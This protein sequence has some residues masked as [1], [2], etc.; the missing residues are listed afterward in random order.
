MAGLI[1]LF[2]TFAAIVGADLPQDRAIDG[3]NI[4]PV[5]KGEGD[6]E[7]EEF[8]YFNGEDLQGYRNALWKVKKQFPGNEATWWKKA[9]PAHDDL[10]I[11]INNDP[12]EQ[13][14]L[15]T[16]YPDT[17]RYLFKRMNTLRKKMGDLPPSL[18]TGTNADIS[19]KLFLQKK[20]GNPDQNK[21]TGIKHILVELIENC[22]FE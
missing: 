8:L 17:V 19:H 1:D 9:V 15:A 16:Q 4:Y 2:P 13:N 21:T 20:Y 3:K 6:R 22:I 10:L 11:D 18:H 14:N 7:N 5:F 12:G